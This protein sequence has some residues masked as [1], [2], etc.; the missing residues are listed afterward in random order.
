MPSKREHHAHKMPDV[1]WAKQQIIWRL[2][3]DAGAERQNLQR[4]PIISFGPT[5]ARM[6]LL[7]IE[8]LVKIREL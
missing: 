6:L 2:E 5:F 8:E 4:L 1:C 3:C 7:R